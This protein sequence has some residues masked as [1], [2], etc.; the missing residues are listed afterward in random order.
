MRCVAILTTS[1]E[2][3]ARF[4]QDENAVYDPGERGS[5]SSER[6]FA[7]LAEQSI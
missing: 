6:T 7:I 2:V 3:I 4:R 1:E 5:L